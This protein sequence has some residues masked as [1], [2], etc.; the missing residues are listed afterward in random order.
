MLPHAAKTVENSSKLFNEFSKLNY[1]DK[2]PNQ[3]IIQ[4]PTSAQNSIHSKAIVLRIRPWHLGRRKLW[5]GPQKMNRRGRAGN[6][7]HELPRNGRRYTLLAPDVA[8]T[9]THSAGMTPSYARGCPEVAPAGD[10]HS[11]FVALP[12]NTDG[13]IQ[14]NDR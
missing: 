6:G 1:L 12:A 8:A 9:I 7:T 14:I 2:I 11:T 13:A 4:N 10:K 3:L 5:A